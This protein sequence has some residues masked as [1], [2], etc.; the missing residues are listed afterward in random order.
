MELYDF[1]LEK[2]KSSDCNARQNDNKMYGDQVSCVY[3]FTS[4]HSKDDGKPDDIL[5]RKDLFLQYVNRTVELYPMLTSEAK[6]D[7]RQ[8][9]Y[10][11]I[12]EILDWGTD[13]LELNAKFDGVFLFLIE[14]LRIKEENVD[15]ATF[16]IP[17]KSLPKE[18][19]KGVVLNI[20][21]SN[22][23][24]VWDIFNWRFDKAADSERFVMLKYHFK[25]Y[26][27]EY[28]IRREG[29]NKEYK[30]TIKKIK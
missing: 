20:L 26:L 10:T 4:G 28:S 30:F 15:S 19:K 16:S 14:S 13:N 7:T 9:P 21:Y 17:I 22:F 29:T 27:K 5:R 2:L 24:D 11:L 8:N 3:L 1:F 25:Q 23:A 6:L 18:I 12:K